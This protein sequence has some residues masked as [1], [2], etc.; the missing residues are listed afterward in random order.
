MNLF[1]T[2]HSDDE[3]LFGAY[4]LLRYK[5][6]ILICLEGRRKRT[7]VPN[8]VR[9]AETAAAAKILGCTSK[10]LPVYCDP[11]DWDK[12]EALLKEYKPSRVWAPLPE[13][14]GHPHHNKVGEIAARLWP[15]MVD[16]YVTYTDEGN[17]RSP[18]GELVPVEPGWPEL[19]RRALACYV[20][21]ASKPDTAFHFE[22][23]VLDE[24]IVKARKPVEQKPKPSPAAAQPPAQAQQQAPI[25]EPAEPLDV[26]APR[27]GDS[28]KLGKATVP[29]RGPGRPRKYP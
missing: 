14:D 3:S 17:G 25:P 26:V 29:Q 9:E 6:L 8:E 18:K 10:Q 15:G 5:P 13:E 12:L 2:P 1:L 4:T 24:Y 20:S 22:H 19:K 23:P 7:Y 21:Q 27:T 16:F 28:P 11:P